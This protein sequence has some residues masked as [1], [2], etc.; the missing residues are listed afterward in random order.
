MKILFLD[1][2]GVLNNHAK[3]PG[4]VYCGIDPACMGRLSRVLAATGARLV[5][6]SAW[7]YMILNGAMTLDGFKYLLYTH[8]LVD[9]TEGGDVV[10]GHTE[11]DVNPGSRTDRAELCRGWLAMN[12]GATTFAAV[13]DLDLG[14]ADLGIPFVQ[15]DGKIGLT[16]ADADRLIE[17]L[18]AA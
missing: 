18:G 6:S 9:N 1:V 17:L 16:D 14:Y 4:S 7:R 15:T 2:D 13:D 3:Q 10:I 8:G 5:I 11:G 12:P